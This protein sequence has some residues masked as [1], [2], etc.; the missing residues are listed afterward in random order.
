MKQ[1][2]GVNQ[3]I[4]PLAGTDGNSGKEQMEFHVQQ[5]AEDTEQQE[6]TM[7]QQNWDIHDIQENCD[8]LDI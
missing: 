1:N 5:F 8:I 7:G 3:P 6:D 2:S 4:S